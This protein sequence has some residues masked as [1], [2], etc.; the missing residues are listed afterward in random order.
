MKTV[1]E[2][3]D[4][5]I[6]RSSKVAIGPMNFHLLKGEVVTVMGPS[7]IGKTTWLMSLMGY[8]ELDLEVSGQRYQQGHLLRPGTVPKDALYIP[9]DEPFPPYWEIQ[10]YLA[11][12]PWGKPS[13]LDILFPLHPKRKQAVQKVLQQLGLSDRAK[14]TVRELS[15]GEKQRAAIAQI[16]LLKPQLLIAD[17]FVSA[18]DPGTSAL[19]LEQFLLALE[20]IGGAAVLALHDPEKALQISDRLLIFWS[21]QIDQQPWEIKR[22]AEA[23]CRP[24]LDTLLRLTQQSKTTPSPSV[25]ALVQAIHLWLQNSVALEKFLRQ[26]SMAKT[27]VVNSDGQWIASEHLTQPLQPNA[28]P[29]RWADLQPYP[30]KADARTGVVISRGVEQP[31]LTVLA[32]PNSVHLSN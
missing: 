12:L 7:G 1:L 16:F 30:A 28:L 19:V 25:Q 3:Q 27:V 31:P 11:L 21:P 2:L 23:W 20:E 22:G 15:G 26:F 18:L 6:Q 4:W 29:F 9:Q 8:E 24:V 17:E 14:A 5:R 32:A 10:K 13:W